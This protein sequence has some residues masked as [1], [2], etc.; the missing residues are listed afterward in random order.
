MNTF[1]INKT[2]LYVERPDESSVLM[3]YITNNHQDLELFEDDSNTEKTNYQP[4]MAV[5]TPPG[6]GKTTF[7]AKFIL[8]I[9][10]KFKF[11]S[12]YLNN[13]RFLETNER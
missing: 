3:K 10:V 5:V 13:F 6:F 7:L 2:Q 12:F 8:N 1:L 4:L 11:K 9:E